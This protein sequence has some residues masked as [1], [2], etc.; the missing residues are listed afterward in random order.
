MT[1][2]VIVRDFLRTPLISGFELDVQQ[3]FKV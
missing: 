3:V 2:A 1:D